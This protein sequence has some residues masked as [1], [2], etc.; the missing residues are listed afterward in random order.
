MKKLYLLALLLL[1]G[2]ATTG[3]FCFDDKQIMFEVPLGKEVPKEP[4]KWW[5]CFSEAWEDYNEIERVEAH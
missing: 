3:H 4:D 2:C 5:D 1:N